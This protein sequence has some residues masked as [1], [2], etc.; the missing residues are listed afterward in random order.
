[1]KIASLSLLFGKSTSYNEKMEENKMSIRIL[2]EQKIKKENID[3]FYEMAKELIDKSRAEEGCISYDLVQCREDELVHYFVE[4]WKDAQAIDIHGKTE[5]F[6]GIVPVLG[7]LLVEPG[8]IQT[9]NK[10]L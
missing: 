5:H 6:T 8:K 9:F 4:E 1:M 3:K 10:V 2:A 7:E